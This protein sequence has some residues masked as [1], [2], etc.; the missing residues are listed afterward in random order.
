MIRSV[1]REPPSCQYPTYHTI[2]VRKRTVRHMKNK[3]PLGWGTR[4]RQMAL[5]NGKSLK[6]VAEKLGRAESS[7][8]SWTNGT[9][10]INLIE[11]LE[12]CDAAGID[13][14]TCLFAGKVDSGF[15]AIGEAWNQA[16]AE[17]RKVFETV[18]KGVLKRGT[19]TSETG[20]ASTVGRR[21]SG[22]TR[23]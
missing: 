3:T 16:D 8:R 14:A 15:L 13:P 2:R 12:L 18:A 22:R 17:E 20:A 19:S 9:R 5:G 10:Q 21:S 1:S 7:V 11:F 23:V 6:D 4:F